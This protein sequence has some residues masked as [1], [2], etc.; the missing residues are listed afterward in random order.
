MRPL[1]AAAGM[2]AGAERKAPSA[3]N[4][5]PAADWIFRDAMSL[6]AA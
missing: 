1:A 5:L 3:A 6:M 2:F 4:M